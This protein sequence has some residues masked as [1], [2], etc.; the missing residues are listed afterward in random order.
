[1]SSNRGRR[2]AFQALKIVLPIGIF[3]YLLSSVDQADYAA[4]WDGEK[5]WELVLAAQTIALLAILLSFFRWWLLVRAFGISFAPREALRLGFLGYLLNFVSFGSVGGDLF[6]A[7][8]VARDKPEKRPEAVTSVLLDRAMGLLGLVALAWICLSVVDV[9]QLSPTLRS[10]RFG[11]GIVCTV[12]IIGLLA[13]I[14]AGN[15]FDRLLTRIQTLPVAG[16]TIARMARAIRRLRGQPL[17]LVAIAF[18]SVCVHALLASSVYLISAGFY[19]EHPTLAEHLMVVPPAMAAGTLPLAPGGLGYQEGA[20][21]GLFKVLPD[22][23]E[24]FS[25]ILVATI[26]RLLTLTA[27]GI[28]L[29][30]YLLSQDSA[31]DVEADV[32]D[33]ST[34]EP[35]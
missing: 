3:A 4:F 20:L 13:S 22:V 8:L 35:S 19:S 27:A 28:G 6:K 17:V 16:D 5:R 23:P 25:G 9:S 1:M 32:E 30:I 2:W 10:I 12:G 33:A 31:V 14:F 7:I 24:S 26:Y 29:V 11:A 21:A 18:V 15:W 34:S